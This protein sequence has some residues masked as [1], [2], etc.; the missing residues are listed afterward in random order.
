ME[1]FAAKQRV[2]REREKDINRG[3]WLEMVRDGKRGNKC[4]RD[5]Q[6]ERYRERMRE[7]RRE[8]R[9]SSQPGWN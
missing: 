2:E 3:E 4:T 1:C 9:V 7:G 5:R 8:E 6:G